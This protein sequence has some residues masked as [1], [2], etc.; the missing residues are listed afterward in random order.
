M[1]AGRRSRLP[2]PVVAALA[3]SAWASFAAV[4]WLVVWDAAF[5]ASLVCPEG[6]TVRL[7]P[8]AAPVSCEPDG[9]IPDRSGLDDLEPLD[10]FLSGAFFVVASLLLAAWVVSALTGTGFGRAVARTVAVGTVPLA[11]LAA[12]VDQLVG[13]DVPFPL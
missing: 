4:V 11:L 13:P 2:G 3:G 8:W 10:V 12:A 6:S 5:R 1:S 7:G 9:A